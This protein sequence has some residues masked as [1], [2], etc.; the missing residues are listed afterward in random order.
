MTTP[1]NVFDEVLPKSFVAPV[2][3]S[4]G[5]LIFSGRPNKYVP[6]PSGVSTVSVS[7]QAEAHLI[8]NFANNVNSNQIRIGTFQKSGVFKVAARSGGGVFWVYQNSGE[9]NLEQNVGLEIITTLPGT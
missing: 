2:R 9:T 8:V 7:T 3:S 1:L 6:I 5:D 4:A